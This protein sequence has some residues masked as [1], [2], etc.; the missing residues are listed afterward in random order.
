M[1]S[2]CTRASCTDGTDD[3]SP[4]L[5]SCSVWKTP[6]LEGMYGGVWGTK[7]LLVTP[8]V[9]EGKTEESKIDG[10]P[11][12]SRHVSLGSPRGVETP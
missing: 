2:W 12:G 11:S 10:V 4:T 3:S 8:V 7:K 9:G 6:S 1:V 5:V